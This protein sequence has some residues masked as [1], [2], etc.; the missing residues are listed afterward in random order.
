V[1]DTSGTGKREGGERCR[2]KGILLVVCVLA[3]ISGA[4]ANLLGHGSDSI[5][6]GRL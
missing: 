2:S 1:D 3:V 6:P 5:F 4:V